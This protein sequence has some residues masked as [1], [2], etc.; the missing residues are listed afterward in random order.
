MLPYK[1]FP[2]PANG[3]DSARSLYDAL[4]GVMMNGRACGSPAG[5]PQPAGQKV[6]TAC[7]PSTKALGI[8]VTALGRTTYWRLGI[9]E[10]HGA[11]W[12]R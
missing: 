3:D 7:R 12:A 11:S 1:G 5:E 9:S 8:V 2:M 10:N 6:T 4:L